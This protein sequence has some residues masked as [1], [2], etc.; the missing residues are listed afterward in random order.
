MCFGLIMYL[1]Q[2]WVFAMAKSI[3][4]RTVETR[5]SSGDEIENVNFLYHD[6]VHALQ[7]AIDSC[8]NSTT[9]SVK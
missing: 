6:I 5:N 9:D 8:I 4:A 7:N 2:G 1:L 3:F